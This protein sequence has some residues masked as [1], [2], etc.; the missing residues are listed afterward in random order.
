MAC[1]L[2]QS[3]SLACR[4]SVG[5]IKTLYVAELENLSTFT[6]ASGVVTAMTMATGKKFWTYQTEKETSM[7]TENIT[8]SDVNGTLFWEQDLEMTINKM[9][10]STSQEI[11][12]LAQ[13]RLMI[14]ALDR[15][16]I[17]WLMGK[18]NGMEMQPSTSTSGKAFGDANQYTLKFKS[19]EET[20]MYSVTS[21]L[22]AA[23]TTPA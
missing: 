8:T 2:T 20:P 19:K 5:G 12:L 9:G 10:A 18:N 6:A 23:L 16:G 17:Y 22:I 3:I 14:I 7:I 13:N 11:K 21:S 4:D 1:A 15:N